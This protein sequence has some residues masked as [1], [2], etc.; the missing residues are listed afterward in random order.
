MGPNSKIRIVIAEDHRLFREGLR[1][2]LKDDKSLEIVG[3]AANGLQAINVVRD[4]KPNV[5]LLDIA[6]PVMDGIQI[7]PAIRQ[8]SPGTKVL[9]LTASK[10]ETTIF[11]SLRAGAKGYLSKDTSTSSLIKAIKAVNND[12]LWLQRKLVARFF[13]GDYAANLGKEDRSEQTKKHLTPREQ[14]VLLLLTKGLT[15]KEIANALFISEKTV[16]NHLNKIFK[17]LNVCRRIE[18]ILAAIK[19]GFT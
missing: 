7:I 9:M 17:K 3:E 5:I 2:I 6:M 4:L 19:L 13:S 11:K 1:L 16:K 10:D 18:A 12:E 15:N 14:D 8:K